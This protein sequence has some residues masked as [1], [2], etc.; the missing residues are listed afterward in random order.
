LIQNIK[1]EYSKDLCKVYLFEMG[2]EWDGVEYDL[3]NKPY[4]IGGYDPGY[5]EKNAVDGNLELKY[6]CNR[7]I[8]C[9]Y[10]NFT[11][12]IDFSQLE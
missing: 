10:S 6:F 5:L 11:L 7:T 8:K 3:N 9:T 12:I 4:P 2:I 1:L